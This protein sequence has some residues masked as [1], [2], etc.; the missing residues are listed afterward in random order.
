MRRYTLS[1]ENLS[2]G[3]GN[4]LAAIRTAAD[5]ATA[6]GEID[7]KRIEISQSGSTTSAQCRAEIATRNTAGT[8]T[9]TSATPRAVNPLGGPASGIAGN[10]D[11]LGANARC[12]V[13]SSADSGGTYTSIR[14]F[15][16]NNLNGYL[17]IPTPEEKLV[18]PPAS[19]LVVR[20]IAAPGTTTGWTIAV[21]FEE[22]A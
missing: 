17:W 8:L 6:G 1:G 7:I 4:V 18:L 22:L 10:A 3:T 19:L 13:N 21:D 12:G 2:L 9:V 16:F 14:P 11:P 5:Q 20:F 15:A